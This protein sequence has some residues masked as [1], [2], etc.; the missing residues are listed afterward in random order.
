MAR[1]TPRVAAIVV[2]GSPLACIRRANAALDLSSALG[3]L[4]A[5]PATKRRGDL[6]RTEL[7]Q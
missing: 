1:L 7:D 2:T 6:V 4:I 5:S 3:R